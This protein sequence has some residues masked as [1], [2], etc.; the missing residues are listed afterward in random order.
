[1]QDAQQGTPVPASEDVTIPADPIANAQAA[2]LVELVGHLD[3]EHAGVVRLFQ[4]PTRVGPYVEIRVTDIVRLFP[5]DEEVAAGGQTV[6]AVC[7]EAAVLECAPMELGE[8][9]QPRRRWPRR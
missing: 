4:S 9:D 1:M 7:R 2:E 8:L 3:A 6:I 5:E